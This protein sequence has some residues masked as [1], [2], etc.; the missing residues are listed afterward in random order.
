MNQLRLTNGALLISVEM[1]RWSAKL[2]GDY[3][4]RDDDIALLW[5]CN[6]WRL[7]LICRRKWRKLYRSGIRDSA[8]VDEGFDTRRIDRR[9]IGPCRQTA[10]R[11][12]SIMR[13]RPTQTGSMMAT[14]GGC[15]RLNVSR[16]SSTTNPPEQIPGESC[17][18]CRNHHRCY[19]CCRIN[20]CVLCMK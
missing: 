14:V 6:E 5:T 8:A 13:R 7:S 9:N 16:R 10:W 15:S 18:I 2:V 11:R 4:L 1:E 3:V 19:T 17:N 12:R 20:S